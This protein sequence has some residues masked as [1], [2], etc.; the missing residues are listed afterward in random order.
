M[1]LCFCNGCKRVLHELWLCRRFL[2]YI[3]YSLLGFIFMTTVRFGINSV[4]AKPPQEV[5][6][7]KQYLL[8]PHM[9]YTGSSIVLCCTERCS[10]SVLASHAQLQDLCCPSSTIATALHL[11]HGFISCAVCSLDG[12][13]ATPAS[14]RLILV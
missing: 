4:T 3:V 11:M 6:H 14:C 10:C 7:T 1:P 8:Q 2:L 13:L 9:V 12:M 5:S